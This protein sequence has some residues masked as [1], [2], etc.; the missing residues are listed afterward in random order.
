MSSCDSTVS[1]SL[2]SASS[3]PL[4]GAL[5]PDSKLDFP[6]SEDARRGVLDHS[7]FPRLRHDST[8]DTMDP[9]QMQKEDPLGI[10]IWKLYARTKSQL[11]NRERMDNLSWRM[12]SISLKQ[13]Q[14]D[15]QR[16][17]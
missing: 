12:M 7:V 5:T 3:R 14:Q 17:R 2:F 16:S 15:A 11:P 13:Q 4:D 1:T 9:V 8:S 10:Q 6:V